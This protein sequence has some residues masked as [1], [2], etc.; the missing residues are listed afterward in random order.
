[1]TG[2]SNAEPGGLR[3]IQ[4]SV[5]FALTVCQAGG[6]YPW[7]KS[8]RQIRQPNVPLFASR[9]PQ[10]RGL[11]ANNSPGS[12]I[13]STWQP[14]KAPLRPTVRRSS[15]RIRNRRPPL[16]SYMAGVKP[17]EENTARRSRA[18]CCIAIAT[19]RMP[20]TAEQD[21]RNVGENLPLRLA[22]HP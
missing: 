18:R 11:H 7:K 5:V 22:S 1:M 3:T 13:L 14:L 2:S 17:R 12:D 8:T 16:R 9:G 10:T 6:H 15:T 21:G 20:C 4:I 19:P